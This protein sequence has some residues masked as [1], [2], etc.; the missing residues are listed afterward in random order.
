MKTQYVWSEVKVLV[1]Q[2]CLTLHD[3]RDWSPPGF[4]VHG[5]LQARTL[6]SVAI[7]FSRGS[8]D[9]GIEPGSSALQ[10]DV[11]S[12]E[13]PSS[14]WYVGLHSNEVSETENRMVARDWKEKKMGTCYLMG[15][16]VQLC[17]MEKFCR[18]F[19]QPCTYT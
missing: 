19:A 4:P 15:T 5:F 12:S 16:E 6:E 7:S 3:P 11:L 8:S 13:P 9:P 14:V 17:K 2:L 1:V 18:L 10:A